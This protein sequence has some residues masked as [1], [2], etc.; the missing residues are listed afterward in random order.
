MDYASKEWVN[1]KNYAT[2]YD[3]KTIDYSSINNVPVSEDETGEQYR[4]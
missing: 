3:L 4:R 2:E 1:N